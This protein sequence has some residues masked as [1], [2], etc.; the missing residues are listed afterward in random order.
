MRLP[1]ERK[2]VEPLAAH[3]DRLRT[4]ARH[5][6]FA[7][8]PRQ[9]GLVRCGGAGARRSVRLIAHGCEGR[10]VMDRGRDRFS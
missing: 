3:L 2:S 9:V 5:Q 6:A 10:G 7:P 4:R 8:F 1:F